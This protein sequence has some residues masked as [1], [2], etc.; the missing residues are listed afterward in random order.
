M[1]V[2]NIISRIT[3]SH[4]IYRATTYSNYPKYNKLVL[5]MADTN[6]ITQEQLDDIQGDIMLVTAHTCRVCTDCYLKHWNLE[7]S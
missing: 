2:P 6:H 3:N 1:F 5:N 7:E 4:S